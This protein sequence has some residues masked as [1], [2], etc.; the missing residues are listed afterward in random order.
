MKS[1]PDVRKEVE[2]KF[3]EFAELA[4]TKLHYQYFISK[5]LLNEVPSEN[6]KKLRVCSKFNPTL[7]PLL[8]DYTDPIIR[9]REEQTREQPGKKVKLM[10]E[11]SG[12]ETYPSHD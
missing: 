8:V 2:S 11:S 7:L 6:T 3:Q 1:R 12:E 9:L 10:R 4:K 5:E